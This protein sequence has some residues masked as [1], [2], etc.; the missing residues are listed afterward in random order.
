MWVCKPAL[1]GLWEVWD[2]EADNTNL[3]FW[4]NTAVVLLYKVEEGIHSR[5]VITKEICFRKMEV[6]V[7]STLVL[8]NNL[9]Q[10]W[11]CFFYCSCDVYGVSVL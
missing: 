10:V 3:S 8:G 6:W 7:S 2:S 1:H 11:F 9:E 4:K 5:A